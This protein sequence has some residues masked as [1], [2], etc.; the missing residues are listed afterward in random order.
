MRLCTTVEDLLMVIRD[1]H[2]SVADEFSELS[3]EEV[4][5]LRIFYKDLKLEDSKFAGPYQ[6]GHFSKGQ[7]SYENTFKNR[8]EG[9]RMADEKTDFSESIGEQINRIRDEFSKYNDTKVNLAI[10]GASG[11][12]KSTLI[13]SLA[14]TIVSETSGVHSCTGINPKT[15]EKI[16]DFKPR[17]F[18]FNNFIVHDLPGFGDKNFSAATYFEEFN[19][20]VFDA[21]I[22]VINGALGR[23]YEHDIDVLKQVKAAN[24]PRV[25]VLNKF[26]SMMENNQYDRK[27]RG[28]EPN[29]E[30]EV[31]ELWLASEAALLDPKNEAIF[32]IS[33]RHHNRYEME[34]FRN[35]IYQM[36]PELKR[37][38]LIEW[39]SIQTNAD[40]LR[41]R[42]VAESRVKWMGVA[43]AA[44]AFAP[45][46]PGVDVAIDLG[47]LGA[48]ATSIT[49]IYGLSPD[50]L[51]MH[52]HLI[53]AELK[54]KISEKLVGYL[55]K[56]GLLFFLKKIAPRVA[57]KTFLKW[58]PIIGQILSAGIG[59]KITVSFGV[60]LVDDCESL[61]KEVLEAE[62]H[63]QEKKAA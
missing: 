8:K 51:S 25:I 5:F 45:V 10:V 19:L 26:D 59:Y 60:D 27:I 37:L 62:L 29:T 1:C 20:K 63:E 9:W 38:R 11:S 17:Y 3:E 54:K 30:Q 18:E 35:H 21:V 42:E 16:K 53:S 56:E 13:N 61:A 7:S 43:A 33:S 34:G 23:V 4:E 28:L 55:T 52:Q 15:Y 32:C 14:G 50:Q 22:F 48:L 41:K 6:S 40:L 49:K 46:P 47:I 31:K 39:M 57:A 36:L 12:G 58:I 24:I 44:N 2:L